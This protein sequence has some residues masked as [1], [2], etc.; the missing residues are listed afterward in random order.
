MDYQG[1]KCPCYTE[2]EEDTQIIETFRETT[3]ISMPSS[4]Y[5]LLIEVV[6]GKLWAAEVG[7]EL[8]LFFVFNSNLANVFVK[9]K[10]E[11]PFK[12]PGSA[13]RTKFPAHHLDIFLLTLVL[14]YVSGKLNNIWKGEEGMKEKVMGHNCLW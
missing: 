4:G 14:K 2:T 11:T 1:H 9:L 5:T 13:T 10:L 6:I 8:L 3:L 7:P 12:N